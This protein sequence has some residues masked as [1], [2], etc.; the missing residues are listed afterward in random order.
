MKSAAYRMDMAGPAKNTTSTTGGTRGRTSTKG[1][2]GYGSWCG[3]A[4]IGGS[5]RNT[6]RHYLEAAFSNKPLS[7]FV[8][9]LSSSR[10]SAF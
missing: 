9:V 3:P 2:K 6:G 1:T 7:P 4:G 5:H 10:R 8:A